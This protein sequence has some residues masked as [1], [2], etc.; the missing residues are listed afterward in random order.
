MLQAIKH[1]R[2]TRVVRIGD[3]VAAVEGSNQKR[4]S[5]LPFRSGLLGSKEKLA[6]VG[7]AAVRTSPA[8]MR[9]AATPPASR[10]AR[11]ATAATIA[12]AT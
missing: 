3:F 10:S 9:S 12:A 4:K 8:A 5:P 6:A 1:L 11:T 7:A 2:W